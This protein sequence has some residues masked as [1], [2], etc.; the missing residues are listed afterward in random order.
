MVKVVLGGMR[1]TWAPGGKGNRVGVSGDRDGGGRVRECTRLVC[2][3]SRERRASLAPSDTT[4]PEP[5]PRLLTQPP[6]LPSRG[7]L[8]T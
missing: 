8:F 6:S 3:H 5:L 7:P 2:R 4:A 1:G